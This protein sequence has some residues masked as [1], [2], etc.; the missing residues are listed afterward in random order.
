MVFLL[1]AAV[2]YFGCESTTGQT[3]GKRLFG[4]R[5]KSQDGTRATTRGVAIRTLLRIIDALPMLYF[6]GFVAMMTTGT[7]R[8]RL[9]DLAGCTFV[10][11]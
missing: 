10:T 2:Y 1:I 5:V 9:S 3:V 11:S 7:R 4:I 6:V 8:Q